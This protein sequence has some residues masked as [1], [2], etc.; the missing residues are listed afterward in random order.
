VK[1]KTQVKVS[2]NKEAR[3]MLELL[4]QYRKDH[5]ILY[6][7]DWIFLLLLALILRWPF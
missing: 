4:L 7:I 1:S 2:V 3:K 5:Q 6:L